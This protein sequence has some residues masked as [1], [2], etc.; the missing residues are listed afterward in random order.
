MCKHQVNIALSNR[1][2]EKIDKEASTKKNQEVSILSFISKHS[3][4]I[5]KTE[6]YLDLKGI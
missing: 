4:L 3:Y 2:V 6:H 1:M 5:T